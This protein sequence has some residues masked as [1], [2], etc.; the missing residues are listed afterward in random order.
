LAVLVALNHAGVFEID[1]ILLLHRSQ[2]VQHLVSRVD[3]V[4][5]EY[6]QI[7]HQLSSVEHIERGHARLARRMPRRHQ[8]S[9]AAPNRS[10]HQVVQFGPP[11]WA[12]P[13][14]PG[15]PPPGPPPP[16][17]PPP[18]PPPPAPAPPGPP[19]P[20]PPPPG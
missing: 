9:L 5:V 18:G 16:G 17:P 6:D 7:A 1:Q 11:R 20:G 14:P 4:E 13:P 2:L 12:P 3:T 10:R 19:P 8:L 15:P